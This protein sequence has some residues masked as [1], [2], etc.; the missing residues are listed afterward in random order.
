MTKTDFYKKYKLGNTVP[1]DPMHRDIAVSD[2]L[3]T[4]KKFTD[5]YFSGLVSISSADA[6]DECITVSEEYTALF[7]KNLLSHIGG[8][9]VAVIVVLRVADR[10]HIKINLPLDPTEL[11]ARSMLVKSAR[12]AGFEFYLEEGGILLRASLKKEKFI[13]VYA[14]RAA[15]DNFKNAMQKIFFD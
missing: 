10:I 14:K 5:E 4:L 1:S 15:R 3:N 11:E 8:R 2:F 6:F 12:A 13:G 7:F 9:F